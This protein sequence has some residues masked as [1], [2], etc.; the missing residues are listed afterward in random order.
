MSE[1]TMDGK[2]IPYTIKRSNR[3]SIGIEVT[4]EGRVIIKAPGSISV[5]KIEQLLYKKKDWLLGTLASCE[6]RET[7]RQQGE[8]LYLGKPFEIKVEEQKKIRIEIQVEDGAI[9]VK[10][11]VGYNVD[12][13]KVLE[14]WLRRQAAAVI[15]EKVEQYSRLLGVTYQNI[16]IK[17][18]KT[19]WGSCSSR[20]NLNFNYRLIMAPAEVL[21]YVVIHELAHRIHMN[22]SKD[23]WQTVEKVCPRY[24]EHRSWLQEFG[25]QLVF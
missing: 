14:N 18:Q 22:H 9:I 6:S 20:G 1:L 15:Q 13:H 2:R 11:P 10:K 16:T 24:R 8:L 4:Y 7:V 25:G 17:D 5:D 23:F 19:R 21:D 3:K 12:I